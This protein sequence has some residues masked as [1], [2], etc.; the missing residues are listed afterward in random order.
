MSEVQLVNKCLNCGTVLEGSY[1]S[2]CGQRARVERLSLN[3]LFQDVREDLVCGDVAFL[4]TI[5][6]LFVNPGRACR[7]Y[8]TGQRRSIVNPLKFC[9]WTLAILLAFTM[10][11]GLEIDL[12]MSEHILTQMQGDEAPSPELQ[13][14]MERAATFREV[15]FD[16]MNVLFFISFPIFAVLLRFLFRRKG[17][18]FTE[19]FTSVLL[20]N[21]QLNIYRIPLILLALVNVPTSIILE[22]LIV[23]AYSTWFII[24]FFRTRI[25]VGVLMSLVAALF[26]FISIWTVTTPLSILYTLW[27]RFTG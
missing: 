2:A 8:V 1:C 24:G 4:H 27:P 26:F 15:M 21:G 6:A 7:E 18:N 25:W 22:A 11:L 23:F 10:L 12:G 16:Y 9:F 5:K 20:V 14:V 13:A 3:H 19:V 17:Y